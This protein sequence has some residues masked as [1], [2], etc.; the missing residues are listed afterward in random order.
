MPYEG[1]PGLRCDLPD[2]AT[3]MDFFYLLFDEGMWDILVTETNKY[4]Q[5][6]IE[7]ENLKPYSRLNDWCDVTVDEMKVFFALV[8]AMGLVRK[9]DIAQYWSIKEYVNTS[10]F[11]KYM[12]RNRFHLI[13]SNRHIVDNNLAVPEGKPGIDIHT[14]IA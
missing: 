4:A 14:N 2:Q 7:N 6:R 11:G 12:T 10:F 13:L 8:I 5:R 3:P 1:R 9:S